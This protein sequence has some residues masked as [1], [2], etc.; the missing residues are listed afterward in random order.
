MDS[1]AFALGYEAFNQFKMP[2]ANPFP[3]GS[4]LSYEWA[5]GYNV[6]DN[7][8]YAAMCHLAEQ[9]RYEAEVAQGAS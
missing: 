7:D 9:A 6:A 8:N 5:E 4:I 2:E 3:A 1:Y